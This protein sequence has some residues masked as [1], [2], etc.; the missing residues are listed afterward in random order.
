ME[1]KTAAVEVSATGDIRFQGKPVTPR[2]S[3]R[4]YKAIAL[5]VH[6]LVVSAFHG[7]PPERRMVVNHI[8]GDPRNNRADN[9]EWVTQSQNCRRIAKKRRKLTDT[10]VLEIR[11]L[12][13]E[14]PESLLHMAR[15]FGVSV[16]TLQQI[17]SGKNHKGGYSK[18]NRTVLTEE[19]YREA[20]DW[21][22]PLSAAAVGRQYG[23][24]ET[25][26]RNLWDES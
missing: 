1:W 17:R 25:L 10:Q 23:V 3:D 26:V 12:Q 24:S 11:A 5:Q 22:P 18:T 19:Q 7:P 21:K 9:L 13:P 15:R 14:K 16:V 8:D 2:I 20:R 6:R 4:G